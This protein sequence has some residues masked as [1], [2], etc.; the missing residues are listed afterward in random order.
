VRL[1][2]S[3]TDFTLRINGKK[4]PLSTK[5]CLLVVSSLND[6]HRDP[7]KTDES[8]SKGGLSTG[9]GTD[10]T[11]NQPPPPVK[12]PF[13]LQRAMSL[14]VQK[15][16]LPEGDRPLPV[17]GLIF[18]PYRGAEKHIRSV[19]LV[20]EGPAGEAILTLQ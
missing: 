4:S 18:F 20:Y 9:N 15:A 2:L 16:A 10:P 13:E 17:A 3:P 8:K 12:V 6:P 7:P 19:E 11:D 14:R 5:P 1:K